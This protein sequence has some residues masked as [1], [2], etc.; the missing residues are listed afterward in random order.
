MNWGTI[1][2]IVLA[3]LALRAIKPSMLTWLA[4]WWLGMFCFMRFGFVVPV[5]F[6]IIKIYMSITS[7]ALLAYILSDGGRLKEVTEPLA[8]F[9][10]ER[11]YQPILGL[12]VL[13]VPA[14][15]AYSTYAGMTKAP[16]APNFG[17]T[18]HPA[19][20][21]EIVSNEENIDLVRMNNPY[22]ELEET[23]PEKFQEHVKAGKAVYYKNCFYCHGDTL[24]AD[25]MFAH[26]LNPIPTDFT[27][28]N[29]L[30]QFTESFFFW[31]I[32]KGAPGLPEE[33]GPWDSAMPAW[34]TFLSN[35]DMWNVILFLYEQISTDQTK[36]RPRALAD[37]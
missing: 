21:E 6:S 26:G 15:F 18:V 14:L 27:G 9:M 8:A 17:R 29:V 13:A 33:G 7:L 12:T 23:D 11:R 4:A 30:P 35:E 37:H 24:A 16:V 22:R 2:I 20:P 31:R 25:G 19:S 34:E 10:T 32:S 28:P 3:M 5:P 1:G 36:Y